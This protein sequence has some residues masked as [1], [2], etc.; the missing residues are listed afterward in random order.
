MRRSGPHVIFVLARSLSREDGMA[1]FSLTWLA[2]VLLDA[3]LKVS[4]TDG[5]KSRG[6]GEMG[7]VK[8]VMCHHTATAKSAPGNM[9]TLRMLIDGRS[10]LPGPLAQ[11]GLGRDGS[12]YIIAAGRCNHAGKGAWQ[13][14]TN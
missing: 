2:Q 6:R 7:T 14:I 10:D 4:E 5:W 8:G 1:N 13:G 9:P 12:F 3:G 11:L